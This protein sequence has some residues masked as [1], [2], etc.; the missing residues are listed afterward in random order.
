MDV[1]V[2]VFDGYHRDL[3]NKKVAKVRYN[4]IKGLKVVRIDRATEIELGIDVTDR[5]HKYIFI[6]LENGETV[7]YS[8]SRAYVVRVES[9]KGRESP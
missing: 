2:K 1:I 6:T 7:I 3:R 5:W 4:N 9:A 8:D